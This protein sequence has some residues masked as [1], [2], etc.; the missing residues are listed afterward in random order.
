MVANLLSQ[1]AHATV[2]RIQARLRLSAQRGEACAGS[3]E[4]SQ[5]RHCKGRSLIA[6]SFCAALT[7]LSGLST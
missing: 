6:Q 1:S 7:T 2:K 5:I 3:I 4:G